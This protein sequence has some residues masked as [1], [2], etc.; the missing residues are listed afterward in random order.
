MKIVK[1]NAIPVLDSVA[2]VAGDYDAFIVDLWGVVHDGLTAYPGILDALNGLRRDGRRVM[3][4]S[5]APR[6]A[7]T[8][9]QKVRSVGVPD[10]FYDHLLSSGEAGHLALRD[11]SDPVHAGLGHR[12]FHIG[13]P[14]DEDV[15]QG[16]DY[17]KVAALDAA[18]WILNTGIK[19]ISETVD[20]FEETLA[21]ARD[22]GLPMVCTNP[23]LVVMQGEV[24]GICA[25]ML[26]KRYEE[27]GGT[28]HYH[29]KPHRG[30]YEICLETLGNPAPS[31][32]LAIGDSFRTDIKGANLM[33]F[34]S[35]LVTQGIHAGDLTRNGRPDGALIAE[36]AAGEAAR[37]TY[38]I[39]SLTW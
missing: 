37:P 32:V 5:N 25:G 39:R 6:R 22:R 4:L 20:L 8:V 21:R 11:R 36:A 33:G 19:H 23:D 14:W 27:L 10:S 1:D 3:L 9:R 29:G 2:A 15:F 34:D 16:L 13:A 35:L 28:A 38:A 30:V 24:M 17:E 7:A 26:A 31:R 18:D 12:F